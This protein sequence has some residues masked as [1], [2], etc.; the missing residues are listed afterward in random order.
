MAAIFEEAV[1]DKLVLFECILVAAVDYG[2][3][4]ALIDDVGYKGV[5]A[6]HCC[7]TAGDNGAACDDM[8]RG[9]KLSLLI[10]Y[11]HYLQL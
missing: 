7:N 3:A 9:L 10:N 5:V 8:M 6:S 4:R 1:Y 2:D 11:C